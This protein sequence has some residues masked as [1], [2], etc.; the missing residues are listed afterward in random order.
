MPKR[1]VEVIEVEHRDPQWGISGQQLIKLLGSSGLMPVFL[2]ARRCL[3][4]PPAPTG[5]L[6]FE[7][8]ARVH[9]R[10]VFQQV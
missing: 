8:Q 3:L 2:W 9:P 6:G 1:I 10:L 5:E 4:L 7:C